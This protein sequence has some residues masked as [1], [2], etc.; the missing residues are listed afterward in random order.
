MDDTGTIPEAKPER[1]AR[2]VI[3]QRE[4]REYDGL[5]A[6]SG[7]EPE[8]QTLTVGDFV[9][10][11]RLVA[12]RKSR[13]DFEASIIDGRLFEQAAR[14]T[15]SYARA[16][17]VVEGERGAGEEGRTGRVSRAALLGAYGALA[18]DFGLTLFFTKNAAGT[19][20]LLAALARHEQLARKAQLRVMAKPKSLTVAQYQRAMVECLPGVGPAMARK[21]LAHFGTPLN[22]LSADEAKL[23]EVEGMGPK[24]AKM[25]RNVLDGVYSIEE[26]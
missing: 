8:R 19:A 21:L 5:L 7:C 17:L 12:E 14:L 24:K 6:Q 9:L 26:E 20:E 18:A 2:I 15:T 3:D 13:G 10:S 16:V 23:R 22:V 11:E 4:S 1:R 25:I